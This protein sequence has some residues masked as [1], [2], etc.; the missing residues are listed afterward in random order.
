MVVSISI[1]ISP[2]VIL[3]LF[4]FSFFCL[5]FVNWH[6]ASWL[7]EK[8]I[9]GKRTLIPT[10]WECITFII[11]SSTHIQLLFVHCPFVVHSEMAESNQMPTRLS[12]EICHS[13]SHVFVVRGQIKHL[14]LRR[15][16]KKLSC[17]KDFASLVP[18]MIK[19]NEI[20]N[21]RLFFTGLGRIS[22]IVPFC[23]FLCY[24]LW[25]SYSTVA[26]S[27][28]RVRKT[29]CKVQIHDLALFYVWLRGCKKNVELGVVFSSKI[30]SDVEVASHCTLFTLFTLLALFT[31]FILIRLFYTAETVACMPIY[32]VRE[33]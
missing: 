33:G 25:S 24:T 17:T 6:R 16:H 28:D 8:G 19:W 18:Y 31:L 11:A 10:Y 2:F 22:P 21:T 29:A 23:F 1:S 20:L 15:F 12:P 3:L 14:P 7:L 30:S 5:F 13:W 9:G 32:I 27:E 26:C 4:S